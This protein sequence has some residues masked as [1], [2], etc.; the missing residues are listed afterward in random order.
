M[1]TDDRLAI[2]E[3]Q[4]A[5]LKTDVAELR[6]IA[7]HR[8][9]FLL[10]ANQHLVALLELLADRLRISDQALIAIGKCL[11]LNT[12]TQTKPKKEKIQ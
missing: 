7:D 4:C 10:Q 11:T 8:H 6:A 1:T 3:S 9:H 5:L 2:L 12:L